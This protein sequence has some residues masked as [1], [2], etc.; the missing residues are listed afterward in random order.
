MICI[1]CE[2]TEGVRSVSY[3]S[4]C[5]AYTPWTKLDS[6]SEH[7]LV[8]FLGGTPFCYAV[9]WS[10][11]NFLKLMFQ[12][13]VKEQVN[14]FTEQFPVQALSPEFVRDIISPSPGQGDLACS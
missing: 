10:N 7:S 4:F 2:P 13:A 6:S 1:L 11:L 3:L 5:F 9:H 8:S 14:I 12:R